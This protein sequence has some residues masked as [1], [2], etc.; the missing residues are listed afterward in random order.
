MITCNPT[1]QA[2]EWLLTK[3]KENGFV[4]VLERHSELPC[5]LMGKA[6]RLVKWMLKL[7]L[8]LCCRHHKHRLPQSVARHG[9]D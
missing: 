9:A 7:L 6:A 1:I 5:Y 8:W 3:A 4:H 2:L